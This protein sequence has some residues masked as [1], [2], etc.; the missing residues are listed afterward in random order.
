MVNLNGS[1]IIE[2]FLTCEFEMIFKQWNDPF[3]S[4]WL[5]I[6]AIL[7]Y[8]VE[9]FASLIMLAFVDQETKGLFGHYRTLINQLLSYL[10]GGAAVYGI[11][12]C[13]IRNLRVLIGPLSKELCHIHD[14]FVRMLLWYFV[15]IILMITLTKFMFI[16]VWKRMPT[17]NDDLLARIA[18]IK[19][20][21]FSVF[22]GLTAPFSRTG[23][24]QEIC[25]GI[26]DGSSNLIHYNWDPNKIH[27]YTIINFAMILLAICLMVFVQIGRHQ[28][29]LEEPI[30][31]IQAP[32]NFES[33]LLNF[34]LTAIIALNHIN[35]VFYWKKY[36]NL[37]PDQLEEYPAWMFLFIHQISVPMVAMI[38]TA[39]KIILKNGKALQREFSS[40]FNIGI[41]LQ[42]S[43]SIQRTDTVD[44]VLMLETT[45][46]HES[47]E[48]TTLN[49]VK[50]EL[51]E[52]ND[53]KPDLHF[54]AKG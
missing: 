14:L 36:E 17:M 46:D 9:I 16:C 33:A 6:V 43:N 31:M 23:V 47:Q 35:S 41:S 1:K 22:L 37:P 28:I 29:N 11:V 21:F 49:I 32:K 30:G 38:I 2:E 25:S 5:K 19:A 52:P 39:L 7:T 18:L 8:A 48:K 42:C 44:T 40:E 24:Y 50:V 53:N 4:I 45:Q 13:G 10:Y 12:C 51:R 15:L 20:F 54:E 34:T 3:D 26:F 27:P